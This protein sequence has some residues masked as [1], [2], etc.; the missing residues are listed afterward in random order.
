MNIKALS[1]NIS[2]SYAGSN[3][4]R[5]PSPSGII[6]VGMAILVLL[7]V[8]FIPITHAFAD[9]DDDDDNISGTLKEAR[10]LSSSI[11]QCQSDYLQAT[12]I[13]G[14]KQ[15][16]VDAL[17]DELSG[18]QGSLDSESKR[19]SDLMEQ[20]Y[21]SSGG[22]QGL[23]ELLTRG[24]MESIGRFVRVSTLLNND[25]AATIS[26]I[27]SLKQEKQSAMDSLI[28][29]RT[30]AATAAQ[31]AQAKE[32]ELSEQLS[33]LQPKIKDYEQAIADDILTQSQ[34]Q[35]LQ[36]IIDFLSVAGSETGLQAKIVKAAYSTPYAG[37][38]YCE[39]WAMNVYQNAG[40]SVKR[41]PCAWDDCADNMRSTDLDHIPTGAL[42]YGGGSSSVYNHVG[43]VVFGSDGDR[44][45]V[46]ILDN[47]GARKGKTVSLQEWESWQKTVSIHTGTSGVFGWGYPDSISL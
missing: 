25:K 22:M 30:E 15:S 35:Q 10:E 19:L 40:V 6:I 4:S 29:D 36:T 3:D 47:E 28:E 45:T 7:A 44:S 12:Q 27:S 43:V 46:R 11:K 33:E 5:A 1:S 41:Y 26:N 34:S 39:R 2:S 42:I 17:N 31:Q 20:E 21:K 9:D 16:Q 13:A 38:N 14:E 18:I 32:E 37:S 24:S 8:I 23:N